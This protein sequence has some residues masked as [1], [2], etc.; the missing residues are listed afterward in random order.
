M[1]QHRL[2]NSYTSSFQ[3]H[4]LLMQSHDLPAE[5]LAGFARWG[6]C[7]LVIQF[8]VDIGPDL[9]LMRP[10]IQFSEDD[11]RTICFSSLPERPA[12]AAAS[13][14]VRH[15]NFFFHNFRFR[16]HTLGNQLVHGACLFTQQRDP[17]NVRGFVQESL[18]LLS[19][20][21]YAH[22]LFKACLS[23]VVGHENFTAC[24]LD[25]KIPCI[26]NAIANMAQWPAPNPA[27]GPL[28]L[29]FLGSVYT[30]SFHN[31]NNND[32]DDDDS[33]NPVFYSHQPFD[34]WPHLVTLLQHTTYPVTETLYLAYEHLLLERPVAVYA[35]APHLCTGLISCL[36]TLLAPLRYQDRV[37]EYVTIQSIPEPFEQGLLGTTNPL[38][39]DNVENA[40]TIVL[41][42]PTLATKPSFSRFF[43]QQR[44]SSLEMSNS[45]AS[46]IKTTNKLHFKNRLLNPQSKLSPTDIHLHFSSLTSKLL[47]PLAPF[48]SS[49]TPF[50]P[51]KFL[52]SLD[53]LSLPSD[54][55]NSKSALYDFYN[56]FLQTQNFKSLCN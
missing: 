24:P 53:S 42:Q 28:S 40:L 13:A 23:S 33:E 34:S 37:R 5:V 2:P 25:Q 48:M 46:R 14:A 38:V 10:S 26:D 31:N 16:A 27:L 19:F 6:L 20:H 56:T 32:D 41:H 7:F 49:T 35:S 52:S 30:F 21:D 47:G 12:A 45:L 4:E 11:F 44:S 1:R 18:V 54:I 15:N 50:D 36:T 22:S 43:A 29:P 17:L 51:N 3:L 39:L 9:K 8:D 55:F